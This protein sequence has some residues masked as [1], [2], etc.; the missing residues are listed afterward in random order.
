[1]HQFFVLFLKVAHSPPPE[2][3]K[4]PPPRGNSPQVG[5]HCPRGRYP[6]GDILGGKYPR[7][8]MPGG[9]PGGGGAKGG[10]ILLPYNLSHWVCCSKNPAWS[11]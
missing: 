3:A 4:F 10:D 2:M 9:I 6:R 5:D 8:E 11:N 7:G 1:M